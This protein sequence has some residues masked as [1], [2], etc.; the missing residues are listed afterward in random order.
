MT[1]LKASARLGA[2]TN[3]LHGWIYF[4][5][6]AAEAYRALGLGEDHSYFASRAAPMGEVSA[7]VVTATFFNFLPDRVAAAIPSAWAIASP[8]EVQTAR[9][10]AAGD[11]LHRVAP[12]VLS[13]AELVKANDVAEAIC[14]GVGYEGRALGGAN[15]AV[16][17]PADPLLAL[18]QR[19]T[20]IR[21]WR[22]DAHVAVLVASAV[23]AVEALVLH[24]GT[25]VV[26]KG[27]LRST[28]GWSEEDWDAGVARLATRGMAHDD[29]SLTDEGV[30]FRA[31]IERRTDEVSRPLVA[32]VGEDAVHQF[33]DNLRPLRDAI[34]ASGVFAP[35]R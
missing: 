23:D 9:M 12:D 34:V 13:R 7:A 33:V 15:R 21:E 11:M 35:T 6:E 22:G 30:G 19:I 2:H 3:L 1:E 4:A 8:A 24:A 16:E 14:A 5:P 18:W 10:K 28:R 27:A 29:G 26:S 31:E 25:G 32:T 17:L 20:T